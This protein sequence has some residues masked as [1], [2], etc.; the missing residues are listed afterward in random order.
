ML[1]LTA[2]MV[3]AMLGVAMLSRDL[4]HRANRLGGALTLGAMLWAFCEV[5][6]NTSND[7]NTVI[8]LVR[9]SAIGAAVCGLPGPAPRQAELCHDGV[10]GK[11]R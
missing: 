2:C 1:P 7:A 11:R 10:A 5:L 6:W 8:R 9:L 3:S 4:R